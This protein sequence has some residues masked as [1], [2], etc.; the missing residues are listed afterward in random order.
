MN[1]TWCLQHDV[2][3]IDKTME[4]EAI[5]SA[6]HKVQNKGSN[7]PICRD[8]LPTAWEGRVF[9]GICHSVQ[10]R[11]RGYSVTARPCYGVV[12]THPTGM[13]SCL[14]LFSFHKISIINQKLAVDQ[15]IQIV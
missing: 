9:K 6:L 11:P 14:Q 15:E 4:L 8:F 5:Q 12:G 2:W 1:F 10:N 7:W 13:L 3:A